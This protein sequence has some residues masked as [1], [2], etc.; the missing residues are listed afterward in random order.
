M[1][2]ISCGYPIFFYKIEKEVTDIFKLY[3]GVFN[4]F[5]ERMILK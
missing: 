1:E 2:V 3:L 4:F 5:N